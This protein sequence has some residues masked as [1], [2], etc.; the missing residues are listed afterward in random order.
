[1]RGILPVIAFLSIAKTANSSQETHD[2]FDARSTHGSWSGSS[3]K[4]GTGKTNQVLYPAVHRDHDASN[5]D[6]LVPKKPSAAG[7]DLF[8]TQRESHCTFIDFYASS[9]FMTA[10]FGAL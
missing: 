10:Y 4:P 9:E 1:M 2:K 6:H 7:M 3:E 5:I 8:Y